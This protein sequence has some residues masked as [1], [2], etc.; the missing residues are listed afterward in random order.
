VL[1]GL[2]DAARYERYWAN[3]ATKPGTLSNRSA[4]AFYLSEEAQIPS[5]LN[6]SLPLEGQARQAFE[7]RNALRTQSRD[8]MSDR[9]LAESLG[10]TDPNMTWNQVVD[11]YS[12]RYSGD[13]LWNKIIGSSQKSRPSVDQSLG[14]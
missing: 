11:K 2:G 7:M 4:R 5:L 9:R 10:R 12:S 1:G 13:A 8:L 3:L 6:R 14:F